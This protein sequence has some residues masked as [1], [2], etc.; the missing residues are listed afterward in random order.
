MTKSPNQFALRKETLRLLSNK[1]L[2]LAVGRG[3]S[4]VVQADS[5]LK[6]CGLLLS[7]K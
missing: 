4:N 6:T 1:E 3:D 7:A 5:G 2:T